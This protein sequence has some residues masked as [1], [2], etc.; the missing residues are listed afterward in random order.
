[1]NVLYFETSA[2][3]AWLLS[4]DRGDEIRETVDAAE[5][6][7]TSALTIAEAERT[8]V[9]AETRG[10]VRPADGMRLRGALQRSGSDWIRM[11]VSEDVLARAGRSFPV[12]P[13]RA[14]DALHLATALE[15]TRAFPD[16]RIL[17]LDTRVLDNARALGIL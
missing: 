3:V 9:R 7:V 4:E 12:E 14:L 13:V 16:L 8:L 1:M 17:S 10:A 11:A 2:V 6:I 15:F 5:V